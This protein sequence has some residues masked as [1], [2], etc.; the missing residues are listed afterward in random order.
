MI[1]S[2]KSALAAVV[3]TLAGYSQLYAADV[4]I[5]FGFSDSASLQSASGGAEAIIY[6]SDTS[7]LSDFVLG[8]GVLS[9]PDSQAPQD[10]LASLGASS[11]FSPYLKIYSIPLSYSFGSDVK[12]KTSIPYLQ[13][14]IKRD[15]VAFTADGLGDISLGVEY[16][17]YNG[18]KFQTST[19]VDMILPTGDV[20][21]KGKNG[22]D[23]LTVPLGSG[24]FSA[25]VIQHTTYLLTND[26]KLFGNIGTRFYTNADY[27]AYPS[28]AAAG[29]TGS[30]IHEE[31]GMVFS[32]MVGTEYRLLND[33]S[34]AGRF[35]VV[36]VQEGKQSA[37]G[38]QLNDSNDSITAGDVSLTL[39]YKI[40]GNTGASLTAII[41][42]FTQYD[43]NVENP[44]KRTW[45]VNL[46][47]STFF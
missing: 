20:S 27:T 45:G 30:K 3:L 4:T 36:S 41:P 40:K 34:V 29:S 11:F 39:K 9:S 8:G 23:Q 44:E 2:R 19:S 13:R 1:I 43:S 32:G 21:A 42:A 31:K 35:S 46:S 25:Y 26:L 37:D 5:G 6:Q 16:R 15:G 7:T 17:W 33:F 38:G 18:T 28:I 24:A 12:I 10:G 47:V 14:T 22:T